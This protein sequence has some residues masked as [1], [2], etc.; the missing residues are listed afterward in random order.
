MT[1]IKKFLDEIKGL[2]E[3]IPKAYQTGLERVKI[4]TNNI[5]EQ[6]RIEY[7]TKVI[8]KQEYRQLEADYHYAQKQVDKLQKEVQRL[9]SLLGTDLLKKK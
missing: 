6:L 4:A 2:Y 3:Q 8:M 5:I 1:E 7:D 9:N